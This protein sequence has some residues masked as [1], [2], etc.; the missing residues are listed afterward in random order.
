MIRMRATT[1]PPMYIVHLPYTGSGTSCLQDG[2]TVPPDDSA[3]LQIRSCESSWR[4]VR[5]QWSF[6]LVVVAVHVADAAHRVV[7]GEREVVGEPAEPADQ[8]EQIGPAVT[9]GLGWWESGGHGVDL[10][11]KSVPRPRPPL[12]SAGGAV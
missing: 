9:G 3:L 12:T 7:R 2:G 8:R 6:S 5:S 4:A 10:P 11:V 1:P